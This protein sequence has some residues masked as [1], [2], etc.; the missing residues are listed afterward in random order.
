[1]SETDPTTSVC[2]YQSSSRKPFD[3][4]PTRTKRW[5][6]F[7][8]QKP[9]EYEDQEESTIHEYERKSGVGGEGIMISSSGEVRIATG[10]QAKRVW[11]RP[12]FTQSDLAGADRGGA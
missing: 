7:D 8:R 12:R 2:S 11:I 5:S 4:P 3:R 6:V 1:M 10:I 9:R